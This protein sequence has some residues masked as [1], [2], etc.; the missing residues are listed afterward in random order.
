M[1]QLVTAADVVWLS[2]VEL[3]RLMDSPDNTP[4]RLFCNVLM[5]SRIYHKKKAVEKLR[6]ASQL[7]SVLMEDA[8][9]PPQDGDVGSLT[10][11]L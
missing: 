7:D 2:T 11:A 10:L 9:H 8:N 5:H 4:T 1:S 3:K 6:H